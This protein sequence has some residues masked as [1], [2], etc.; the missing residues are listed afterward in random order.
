MPTQKLTDKL[1]Q[2][3]KF[4]KSGQLDVWDTVLRS[5]AVRTGKT[6]KTFFVGTRVR[7]KYRRI[8]VGS[9]PAMSLAEARK[10]AG[11]II[12]DAQAGI[13]P[14]LRKNREKAGTF[15]A[16]ALA[17]MQDYAKNH[18]TRHEMQRKINV[19]LAEWHDRQIGDITRADVKELLR[20]KARSAP[21][22]ANRLK[23]QIS[24]IFT[25]ALKEEL[26][27]A[28]PAVSLDAPG[29]Q[30]R[31]RQRDRT[32]SA[33][34][35]NNVW[36]AFDKMG[37]P[38]GTLFKLL[39]VTGQRRGEVGGMKWNE[40]SEDGWRLPNERAKKGKGHLVPLSSLAK[41]ILSDTPQIGEYVF[42]SRRDQPLQGWS[43]AKERADEIAKIADWHIHDLR[44]TFATQLRSVG[45]DRLVVSKLLNHTEAGVTHIYDRY[46]ADPE[47][48]AAMERWA[49]RLREIISGGPAANVVQL[50]VRA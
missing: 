31:D 37:Y 1:L 22:S 29:G 16:V 43:N 11:S 27:T 17:F 32:L 2:G 39:L 7:G 4:T 48:A 28:S 9:Y 45:I 38:F 44:R 49:N 33:A 25:W 5:F 34:E 41:E 6:T 50:A 13:G 24:K 35:I 8:T 12:N 46:G 19:D 40:I 36:S 21:I 14:E 30:E 26:I 20:V 42:R 18:R 47:K 15:G 23:S 3:L 10:A